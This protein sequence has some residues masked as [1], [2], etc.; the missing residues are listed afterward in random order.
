VSDRYLLDTNAISDLVRNPAGSVQLRIANSAD[1]EICT[2]II[3]AAELRFDSA[4]RGS[5]RLYSQLEIILGGL[6][7]YPFEAPADRVYGELRARLERI[8]QPVGANDMLIAAHAMALDCTL[9]TANE[10]EFRCIDGLKVENWL[11]Q[12]G[13]NT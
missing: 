8:G 2:S 13:T 1:A 11:H 3:V 4:R 12:T 5:R 7:V 6:N 10:R 9:V